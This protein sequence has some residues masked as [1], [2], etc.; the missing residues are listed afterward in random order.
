MTINKIQGEKERTPIVQSLSFQI[1]WL[2]TS[3]YIHIIYK[4]PRNPY[5]Q[6]GL[7]LC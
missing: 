7:S 6:K 5:F 4:V 3:T 1:D 2:N